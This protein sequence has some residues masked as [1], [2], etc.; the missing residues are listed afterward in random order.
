LAGVMVNATPLLLSP[1]VNGDDFAFTFE[2]IA[3]KTY[4]IDF[5]DSLDDTA[6]Q[7]LQSV[8]GDGNAITITKSITSASQRFFRLNVQ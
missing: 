4:V 7:T 3:G 1:T 5:K 2:T 8:L 6:W